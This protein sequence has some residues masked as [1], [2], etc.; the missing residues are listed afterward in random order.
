MES[1]E[2]L[3]GLPN[4]NKLDHEYGTKDRPFIEASEMRILMAIKRGDS[5][6]F[7]IQEKFEDASYG[8]VSNAWKTYADRMDNCQITK[9][10]YSYKPEQRECHW[11]DPGRSGMKRRNTSPDLI[12]IRKEEIEDEYGSAAKNRRKR[13]N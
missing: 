4:K 5:E 9:P 12:F 6:K 8:G 10:A 13:S 3:Q 11:G 2:T 7:R 1:R